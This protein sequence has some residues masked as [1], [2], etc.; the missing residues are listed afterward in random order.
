MSFSYDFTNGNAYIVYRDDSRGIMDITCWNKIKGSVKNPVLLP[1]EMLEGDAYCFRYNIAGTTNMRA[2]MAEAS[3]E[4]RFEMREKME[5]AIRVLSRHMIPKEEL[6]L[7]EKYMY[8]DDK[9]GNVRFI[10]IPLLKQKDDVCSVKEVETPLPKV[11]P[12]PDSDILFEE[13]GVRSDGRGKKS[14]TSEG[15]KY[16]DIFSVYSPVEAV[17]VSQTHKGSVTIENEG[18]D[19]TVLLSDEGDNETVLLN[20]KP[21]GKAKLVRIRTQ[22]VYPIKKSECKI[23]KKS[24]SVDICLRNN[25]TFSR[26]HCLIR[27][28]SGDYYL[29]DCGSKNFTYVEEKQVM[30]GEKVKLIDHCRIRLSDEEFIFEEK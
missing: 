3:P 18:D 28:I 13:I 4:E 30:P 6:V 21:D 16:E 25:P 11:T 17:Q 5:S 19:E 12:V 7:E 20:T 15:E 27:Y 10:C 1:V 23:G 22:E 26:Y 14:G 29:E 2:W 8:V 24:T 9:T